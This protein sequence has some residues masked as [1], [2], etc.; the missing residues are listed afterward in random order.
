MS[1]ASGTDERLASSATESLRSL[2]PKLVADVVTEGV[3]SETLGWLASSLDHPLVI[4]AVLRLRDVPVELLIDLATNLAPELQESLLLRQDAILEEPAILEALAANPKLS[5]YSRRRI[6]EY[7]Q[8]LL[9]RE[10]AAESLTGPAAIEAAEEITEEE[11]EE[12]IQVARGE[13]GV[14]EVDE[15]TGLS[16]SQLRIAAAARFASSSAATS[17]RAPC[18][19][20]WCATATPT[21]AVSV[22]SRTIRCRRVRSG[23]DRSTVGRWST[24]S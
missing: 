20:F 1:L 5:S 19:G 6:D 13:P 24:T 14:G 16:E 12:A 21:V 17:S 10:R 18:V 3:P 9:P 11:V 7:R 4:E 2:D 23:A 8:H 22:L 15:M